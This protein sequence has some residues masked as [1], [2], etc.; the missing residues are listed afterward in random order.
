MTTKDNIATALEQIDSWIG[1]SGVPGAAAVIWHRGEIVGR[2]YAGEAQPGT[3]VDESTLFG[4]ASVTKPMTA[5]TVMTL[6]ESD[7]LRSTSQSQPTFLNSLRQHHPTIRCDIYAARSRS[8][9][10]VA[11]LGTTRRFAAWDLQCQGS[12]VPAGDHRRHVPA[13][14]LAAPGTELIFEYR[15]RHFGRVA[16]AVTAANF[17]DVAWENVFEPLEL[18]RHDRAARTGARPPYRRTFLDVYGQG[19][20]DRGVQQPISPICNSVGRSLRLAR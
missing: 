12:P 5:A 15:L 8:P 20:P 7:L 14:A 13:A 10:P 1:E 4:L 9:A 18:H 11:Y 19:H 17:W 6:V 3:P 16:E 2:H